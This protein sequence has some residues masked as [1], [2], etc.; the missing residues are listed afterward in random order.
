MQVRGFYA[1]ARAVGERPEERGE[2]EEDP[3][4]ATA[5]PH[6]KASRFISIDRRFSL[7]AASDGN[8]QVRVSSN[9]G[10]E[11]HSLLKLPFKLADLAGVLFGV[12][13]SQRGLASLANAQNSA[14]TRTVED[15]GVALFA[16]LFQN[17]CRD[18]FSKTEGKAEGDGDGVRLSMTCAFPAWLRPPASPGN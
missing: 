8:Y 1:D 4:R 5:E 18:V 12:E 13:E 16:A 15:L 17:E 7:R 11:G 14:S 9:E 10:G 3:E 2:Q 6:A